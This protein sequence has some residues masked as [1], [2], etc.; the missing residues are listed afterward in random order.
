MR[1]LLRKDFVRVEVEGNAKLLKLEKQ[2]SS[3]LFMCEGIEET[4]TQQH[5]SI[6]VLPSMRLMA[7]ATNRTCSRTGT[8]KIQQTLD[9][10]LDERIQC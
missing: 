10:G 1:D 7:K 8:T 5:L 4:L 6:K 2:C 3:G 9:P